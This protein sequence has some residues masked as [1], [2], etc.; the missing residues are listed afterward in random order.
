MISW[1]QIVFT[2]ISTSIL[3]AV[4]LFVFYVFDISL[5]DLT[6]WKQI[7]IYISCFLSYAI[8]M[9]IEDKLLSKYK[10]NLREEFKFDF[11]FMFIG[12]I[13][14][15]FLNLIPTEWNKL[16]QYGSLGLGCLVIFWW[17][18]LIIRILTSDQFDKWAC[19]QS[20]ILCYISCGIFFA[21]VYNRLSIILHDTSSPIDYIYFSFL[22]LSTTGTGNIEP[23]GLAKLFVTIESV[24]GLFLIAVI[25][26]SAVNLPN[27]IKKQKTK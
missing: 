1:R 21:G 26:S 6:V 3:I 7:L 18:Q 4:Y 16:I 27:M 24:I 2:V 9:V 25:I 22:A 20:S 10:K 5:S 8:I 19:I 14:I 23:H 17:I 15:S 12:I 11:S 13:I